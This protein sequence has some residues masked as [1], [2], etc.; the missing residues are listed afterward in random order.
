MQALKLWLTAA[1]HQPHHAPEVS[2]RRMRAFDL[3]WVTAFIGRESKRQMRWATA[4]PCPH[5]AS[6]HYDSGASRA[7]MD[8][9]HKEEICLHRVMRYI[10]Y[11]G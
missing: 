10:E 9:V 6:N 3:Q 5:C 7:Y 4:F 11:G 1:L 2:R 8:F